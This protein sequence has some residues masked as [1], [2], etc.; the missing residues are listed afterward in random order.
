MDRL[1]SYD[2][3]SILNELR[4]VSELLPPGPMTRDKFNS[5]ARMSEGTVRKRFGTWHNALVAAGLGHRES[6]PGG[7]ASAEDVVAELKRVAKELETPGLTMHDIELYGKEATEKSIRRHFGVLQKAL[8]AA[9]L[10]VRPH[11]RRWTDE[12]YFDNL[13]EVWMHYGRAPKQSEI[14]REPS[15]ITAGAY[16]RKFGTWVKAKQAFVDRVNADTEEGQGESLALEN[17]PVS[18]TKS[19]RV[20]QEDRRDIPIGL[21]YQVLRRDN[22]R[23]V[24]C[25]RSPA[26]D[27]VPRHVVNVPPE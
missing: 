20:R 22:F 9:G 7:G 15:Q 24:G 2:D 4:R 25:G 6:R 27:V 26:L 10:E 8:M 3:E 14:D 12:D 1:V 5:L 17:A 19:V 16:R 18:A 11:Q 23:C 13:L 21:R